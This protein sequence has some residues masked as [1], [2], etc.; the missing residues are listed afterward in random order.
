[1]HICR[2]LTYM[3]VCE[4]IQRNER[5]AT[6]ICKLIEILREICISLSEHHPRKLIDDAVVLCLRMFMKEDNILSKHMLNLRTVFG[7]VEE[8]TATKISMVS[9]SLIMLKYTFLPF[10]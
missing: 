9:L 5:T 1:M 3:E 8:V 10:F 4:Y 2:Y 6:K 7:V